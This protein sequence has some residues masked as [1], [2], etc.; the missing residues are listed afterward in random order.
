[1]GK[2][3]ERRFIKSTASEKLSNPEKWTKIVKF[4][5]DERSEREAYVLMEKFGKRST[6]RINCVSGPKVIKRMTLVFRGRIK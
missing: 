4:L 1:M 3:R 5:E 2:Q 6:W